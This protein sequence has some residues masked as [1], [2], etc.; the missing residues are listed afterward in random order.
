MQVAI[1]KDIKIICDKIN[2][3]TTANLIKDIYN[4]VIINN[5]NIDKAIILEFGDVLYTQIPVGEVINIILPIYYND[6]EIKYNISY[7][8][9]IT[10]YIFEDYKNIIEMMVL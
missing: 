9:I 10:K 1:I 6:N 8:C 5:I 7:K 4:H 3:I 2:I